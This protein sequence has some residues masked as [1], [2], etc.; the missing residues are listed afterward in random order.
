MSD[1]SD[2]AA[3]VD[4][5]LEGFGADRSPESR[6]QLFEA[7]LGVFWNCTKRTLGDVTLAAIVERVLYKAGERYPAFSSLDVTAEGRVQC[8]ELRERARV[9]DDPALREGIRFV[10]IEFLTVLGRL[11]AEI[12]T[13][14]LHAELLQVGLRTSTMRKDAKR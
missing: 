12:L 13:A 4:A 9:L 3:C 6:L 11:T 10:L 2:H 8:H 1:G 7:A 14:E 5:W